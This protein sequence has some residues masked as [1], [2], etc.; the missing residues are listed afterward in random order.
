VRALTA[1]FR[2]HPGPNNS[3]YG[4]ITSPRDI[5]PAVL[6][7]RMRWA[8]ASGVLVFL[9]VLMDGDFAP[10]D[11]GKVLAMEDRRNRELLSDLVA[12][13]PGVIVVDDA[14]S[15]L[16]IRVGNFDY[17]GYFA[18]Y[19]EFVRFMRGYTEQTRMGDLRIFLRK[20]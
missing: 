13:K 12:A 3:V 5:H 8:S 4:F 1:L 15:K 11:R 16:G 2:A 17:L 7:S 19:H 9:P 14:P 20:D 6:E 10:A 18:R